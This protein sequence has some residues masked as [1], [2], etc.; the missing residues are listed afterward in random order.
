[1]AINVGVIGVGRWGCNYLRTLESVSS[2]CVGWVC[3]RSEGGVRDAL[4]STGVKVRCST[5]D[6]ADVLGDSSVDAV[7]IA[8]DGSAHYEIAKKALLSGKHVLVEKPLAFSG[9]KVEELVELAFRKKR[10]LMVSDIHRFNPGIQRMVSD[11]R[12]GIFGRLY[13]AQLVH[14]G[15]G[16]VRQDMSA[17]WD[18][19]PHSASILIALCGSPSSVSCSGASFLKKGVQDIVSMDLGFK[20]GFFATVTGTWLSP[21]KRMDVVLSGEKCSAV[22]DDYAQSNRLR[23]F[24]RGKEGFLCPELGSL[25]PLSGQVRWFIDRVLAGDFSRD[26]NAVLVARVLDA[27][28]KSLDKG[29]AVSVS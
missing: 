16:P 5:A 4:R 29:A 23:Y 9:R 6:Y 17:L 25:R 19:F 18:F 3:S 13:Y 15:N 14:S 28:Q 12:D 27:A 1:M 24:A 26:R 21:L 2:G 8:T 22:F 10:V 11:S 7:V 20:S